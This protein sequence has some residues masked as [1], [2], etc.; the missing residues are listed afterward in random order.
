M[1]S[2][3]LCAPS[4]WEQDGVGDVQITLKILG[5]FNSAAVHRAESGADEWAIAVVKG[6][7]GASA[8]RWRHLCVLAGLLIGFEGQGKI[9]LG[10]RRKLQGATVK[11]VNLTLR[12]GEAG[13]E[14]ARNSIAMIMSHLFDLLDHPEKLNLDHDLLLPMLYQPPLFSR[15]GLHSGYFLSSIDADITQNTGTKF[16][17]SSKSSTYAQCQRMVNDPLISSLGSL[18]RVMAFSVD[19]ILDVDLVSVLVNDL[20]SFTRSL[21]LQWRQNKLSEIDITEEAAFLTDETLRTTLPT[22]WRG[23]RSAMFA[24]VIILRAILGRVLGDPKIPLAGS[25]SPLCLCV[26]SKL[27]R[28]ST[29]HLDPVLTN[30]AKSVFHLL[31]PWRKRVLTVYLRV[32]CVYRHIGA[33][34][35]PGGGFPSTN[36][37]DITRLHTSASS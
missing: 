6:T 36:K 20:F 1:T 22:L 12:E 10:L 13:S 26:C 29:F 24:I 3:I 15:E 17:W 18:S 16:D 14:L 25:K 34:S 9:S 28:S 4:I 19:H 2:Q 30:L 5:I 23:L 8:P 37:T 21:C 27:T 35:S 31:S 7:D 33:I 11:A 32:P